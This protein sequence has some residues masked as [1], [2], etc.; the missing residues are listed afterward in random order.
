MLA[1]YP[2]NKLEH[3]SFLLTTLLRQQPLGV[4]TPETILVESPGMQHWV[5]MQLAT[6]HGVAMNIDYPLP[7]R[8]MWNTARAVLGQDTVP[9]QSPYRREV[10]TWRIDNIL[11]D[12]SLMSGD[13]F[14]QVNRYWQNAGSEQEQGL[15]RLQLATAL[16]DVYEQ[17]LLYRPDWLFKWEANERAVFDDMEIWQSEIWRILAKEQPL[18]PARLHQMT[19]EALDGG[20]IPNQHPTSNLPK[21]VI[22]FAINTMAPQLIAFFDAL[23]QHIDI[24]I[25]HLN[26]SV[27][28]WGEAKSSSEQAKLLRLEGLKKWMEED[29]SNPLL[30]N[31]GKQGRELF[32]LLT[33]LD[34][35]EISAF[36]SPDFDEGDNNGENNR[37]RGLLEYIHNDILR[38]APPKPLDCGL[39]GGD[40]NASALKEKD[41]S[42]TIMCT[43]SALREVQVLHDHL[44]HWLSQDKTR[45]P[46]DILV[47]C[48]AIENYAP[49]VDAV[50][51]RVG[52]KSLAGTGQVRLPCTIADR[53]PMDAEPLIAAFMALLQ[54]P[55]SRFGV[56]DI[57]DYLQLDSV[58][59]RFSVSQD[60]IEQ[61]VVWLKQAHI[62]WGLN[63]A[64]K[65]AVSEGVDL[66][67]TYS[68][69]WGIRRLLMGMLAPDSEVIVSD[70]LTIPDVEGQSALTLGKL[71]DVVALLGEFAQALTA[72]RTPLQWSK[73]LIALRDACFMPIKEQQQS[74][75]LIVKVA[76]DLAARCEEA[77]YE[78][79]LSLRQVRDL[80]LN[81]FSSPDAGNHFMTGQVT[82]CSMLPMRSIPFKKVCIL[83]LN[84]SEFPRK[85]SPLG[86]DLMASSG[87]QIGDRSRRLED[88]YLFLEA[89]I[90]TRESLY[91]SYQ[92]NDVTNNSERQPSLVLAEFMDMLENS[93][94]LDLSKYSVNAPL[95]PFSEA[96]FTGQIPSYETGWLRLADALQQTKSHSDNAEGE[97]A[98]EG[99][100][101]VLAPSA[102]TLSSQT[103]RLSS[104]QIARAFKDPLE[105]FSIQRLGVNLSQSF[106]LLENSEPFET[107]ALLRYQVLD[108]IFSSPER[109]AP[110][111]DDVTQL[112]YS[113]K[114]ITFA[115]LR[116]DI[117]NNPV[118]RDE[119][120][121]WKEGALALSQAM[122]PHDAEPKKAHFQGKYITFTSSALLGSEALV[123]LCAG[124]VDAHRALSFFISQLVFSSSDEETSYSNYPLDIYSCA[125]EK[126]ETIL[127]KQRFPAYDR[128]TAVRLLL[129]IEQLY[130]AVYTAPTPVYL[131]LFGTFMPGTRNSDTKAVVE[132]VKPEMFT[133]ILRALI[134]SAD[135]ANETDKAI[136]KQVQQAVDE[137]CPFID[138]EDDVASE[139]TSEK[140]EKAKRT[141][142]QAVALFDSIELQRALTDWQQSN[143]QFSADMANNPYLNW[144]FP[145]GVSWND[146][147]HLSAFVLLAM[148]NNASQEEKL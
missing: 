31:L 111:K 1:L 141:L 72:P 51:H 25:F 120:D 55:D 124:K 112:S 5:S 18:H 21:R 129:F 23:A 80:L 49:F 147:P 91:L 117:P 145:Q 3:L 113:E 137:L 86:L 131:S 92:G 102:D 17:Y 130:M 104:S 140:H 115:S 46:S 11:Q 58:Q 69:W 44:L 101:A 12:G 34:T 109:I 90:S 7:V 32:N 52:T 19:L 54:L 118:A 30:G 96:G 56:S 103:L 43:H 89:I 68:W 100:T 143:G 27:N 79:E 110:E 127:K 126:G 41:D 106:T 29:Q 138:K 20:H 84:D 121:M 8:F 133:D 83:G 116:G 99:N 59:K 22:V 144:L 36:D 82:V 66:D 35:F 48:P 85:S 45:T 61:M 4:F 146:V 71:I 142:D 67:E 70:L 93:Y 98:D 14:E 87:R 24:H 6:E 26:P 40:V 28:Y 38:A 50:F 139:T 105:Y 62:H 123:E 88:R 122:G 13:A 33:E 81:R 135:G 125:W 9:K 78:H 57:M 94:E 128:E 132:S 2:S 134:N 47:M 148:V 60:D 136:L 74:W 95:H 15:Q 65:T 63:S 39:K 73:A 10:L 37:S 64:H 119:V 42:V 107:N 97:S 114:V 108:A 76:A 75:D 77:G 16:A 53:S